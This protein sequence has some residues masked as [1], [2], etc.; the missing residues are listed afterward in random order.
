MDSKRLTVLE[1]TDDVHFSGFLESGD[2]CTLETDVPPDVEGDLA[3]QTLEGEA[4]NKEFRALLVAPDFTNSHGPRPVPMRL[5]DSPGGDLGHG[6]CR[7][8]SEVAGGIFPTS[9]LFRQ[10]LG[11]CHDD[12]VYWLWNVFPLIVK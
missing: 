4:R 2:G 11:A 9:G 3:D 12:W 5:L 7:F 10:L 1:M 6:L 8:R